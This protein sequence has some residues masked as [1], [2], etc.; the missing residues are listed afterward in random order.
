MYSITFKTELNSLT[1]ILICNNMSKFYIFHGWPQKR[2]LET[3]LLLILFYLHVSDCR[4]KQN[5][6]LELVFLYFFYCNFSKYVFQGL[7]QKRLGQKIISYFILFKVFICIFP[8]FNVCPNQKKVI[9][10]LCSNVF[11]YPNKHNLLWARI[12]FLDFD[13]ISF[14]NKINKLIIFL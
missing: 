4:K 9:I 2:F 1:T 11:D 13:L 3:I 10:R 8:L 12:W 6:I 7:S 5:L 14:I